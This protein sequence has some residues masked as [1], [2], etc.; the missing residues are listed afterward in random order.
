M[1]APPLTDAGPREVRLA[2]MGVATPRTAVFD[3][4][5]LTASRF[6]HAG[7]TVA[8]S[9]DFETRLIWARPTA[10]ETFGWMRFLDDEDR[11]EMLDELR[12]ADVGTWVEILDDWRATAEAISNP[13]RRAMLLDSGIDIAD[14][15]EVA[16]PQ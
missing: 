6:Y 16:R 9:L 7:L 12:A 14:F 4:G 11:I 1:T 8:A 2:R 5:S 10:E 3:A 13:E 15:E